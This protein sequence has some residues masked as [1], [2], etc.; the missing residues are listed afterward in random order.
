MLEVVGSDTG[1]GACTEAFVNNTV[2]ASTD[3]TTEGLP[4]LVRRSARTAYA[5]S[6]A[7]RC[8]CVV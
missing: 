5:Q 1:Q 3:V 4:I 2:V 8:A 6:W 7:C